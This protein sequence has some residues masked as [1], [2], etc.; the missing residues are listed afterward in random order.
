MT[1]LSR[2]DQI[3]TDRLASGDRALTGEPSPILV[4]HEHLLPMAGR[5]VDVAAGLGRNTAWLARVGLTVTA[6]DS[7]VVAVDAID[8]AAAE[9]GIAVGGEQRDIEANGLGERTFDLI[10]ITYFIDRPLLASLAQHLAPGAR[11]LFAQPTVTNL[12]RNDGPSERF[13]LAVGEIHNLAQHL[14]SEGLQIVTAT[15][16]WRANGAHEGWLAVRQR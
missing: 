13:C 5:A 3:Y 1:A 11:A 16:E 8:Q 6:I 12:E 14:Q 9:L 15:E 4:A 10:V 7:S 2:W